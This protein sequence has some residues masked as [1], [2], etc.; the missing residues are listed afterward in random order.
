MQENRKSFSH[1][2]QQVNV[3]N[4]QREV[5]EGAKEGGGTKRRQKRRIGDV[6]E[7]KKA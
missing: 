4:S 3:L 7:E 1:L 2:K 5:G 6:P